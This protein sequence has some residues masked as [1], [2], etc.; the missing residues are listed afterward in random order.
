MI[1]V[2]ENDRKEFRR[3]DHYLAHHFPH[4]GRTLIKKLFENGDIDSDG[5]MPLNL[6]K[7]PAAGTQIEIHVP[8]PI[9]SK[10]V[11]ENI[12]LK[13]LYE[14]EHVVVVYKPSGMVT[15]PAP[16]HYTGTLVNALLYHIPQMQEALGD[17]RPGIVHR[18]DKGTSG[19]MVVA[20]TAGALKKLVE[21]F[22]ERKI[23]RLYESFHLALEK[24][25]IS[26]RIETLLGRHKQ[27]PIKFST[28]PKGGVGKKAISHF[29][30]SHFYDMKALAHMEFK[31]E[32]G[33]THQIRIHSSEILK[34]PILGDPLYA[35]PM[36][37]FNILKTKWPKDLF[38][39]FEKCWVENQIVE[40]ESFFLHAKVLGFHHPIT[41]VYLRF[42]EQAPV[43]FDQVKQILNK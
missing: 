8:P 43:Y 15:H 37:Q 14:D 30:M 28:Q 36:Q 42:E 3:L 19:V 5:V 12:P 24:P 9:P 6:S 11:P 25:N 29:K 33:R 32:T 18:L 4:L 41:N 2:N 38:A 40:K 22:S 39:E 7:M 1:T 34:I 16:G 23:E 20:K 26:G 27:N 21:D 17:E 13:F 31:L 35:S 10:A